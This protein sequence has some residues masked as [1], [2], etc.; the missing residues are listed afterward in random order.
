M[1]GVKV[2]M[3]HMLGRKA[4]YSYW[5]S[6]GK[7]CTCALMFTLVGLSWVIFQCTLYDPNERVQIYVQN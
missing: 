5:I 4:V 7:L 6:L 3:Q 1:L 2:C